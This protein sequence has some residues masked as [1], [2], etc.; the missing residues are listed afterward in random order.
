MIN[1]W[2]FKCKDITELISKS[3]DEKLALSTRLAIKFHLMMCHLCS[4]YKNQ[5]NLI[6]KA[7]NKI[8]HEELSSFPDKKLPDAVD[9][10]GS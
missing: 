1:H 3:M 5:L 8:N 6:Q 2:V 4:R 10:K 7:L 9:G